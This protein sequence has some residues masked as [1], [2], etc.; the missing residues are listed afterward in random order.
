MTRLAGVIPPHGR[1]NTDTSSLG[2]CGERHT[3]SFYFAVH[4]NR[5]AM[6]RIERSKARVDTSFNINYRELLG[7]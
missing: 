5:E 6:D 7:A 3:Q 2:V 1:F 4:W